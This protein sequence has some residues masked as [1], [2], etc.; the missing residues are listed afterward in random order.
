MGYLQAAVNHFEWNGTPITLR[1]WALGSWMNFE[2]FMIGLPGTH[3][4]ILQAFASVY[5]K[6]HAKVWLD[7]MLTCMVDEAD[8]I[9]LKNIGINSIRIPFNYHFLMDDSQPDVFLEEG[10]EKLDRVVR[11]CAKHELFVILDLHSVP[12]SQN[13]DWHSDNATGQPLFWQYRVFQDQVIWL[14]TQL[15]SHYADNPWI[16]GYDV[17]NEPGYGVQAEEINGFYRRVIDAVRKVDPHHIFFL[18]GTDFGRD[19]SVLEKMEDPNI[20]Y[21]V[22]FYPFVLEANILDPNL[23][24]TLRMEIFTRIFD[25]QLSA[26][27][28]LER[29]VWCGESGYEIQDGQEEFYSQLLLHNIGLCEDR[30]IS[31]NL[32]TYKDA[33]C[34]GIV[35]PRKDSRWMTLARRVAEKWSHH[36]EEKISMLVTKELGTRFFTPLSDDQAYDLDFQVRAVVHEIAVEQVLKP[37]LREI[38]WEEMKGY[39]GDFAFDHCDKREI[40]VNHIKDF[41]H[42]KEDR[43]PC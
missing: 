41:I 8:I 25:S 28:R 5:G 35:I 23:D 7:R 31:W 24:D 32:W 40:V 19:F 9:W 11:L 15:A 36:G 26:V 1:G 18:E 12:G 27:A 10:F 4:Q 14:W 22:H 20:A 38:S 30:G 34:M 17:I 13:T 39:A 42:E 21:T 2:H 43:K 6:E 37:L 29:P 16:A 33:R 3:S